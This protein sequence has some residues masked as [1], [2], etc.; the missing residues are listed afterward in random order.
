[1]W[2]SERVRERED[3]DEAEGP[4][5][6]AL[7]DL[8]HVRDADVLPPAAEEVVALEKDEADDDER[9]Q[10][11]PEHRALSQPARPS[12]KRRAAS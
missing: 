1:M 5:G 8:D 11:Q 10:R 12:R 6:D 2:V 9:G 4:C 7:D 3:E